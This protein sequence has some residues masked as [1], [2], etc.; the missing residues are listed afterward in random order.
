MTGSQF[1]YQSEAWAKDGAGRWTAAVFEQVKVLL[2]RW[3]SMLGDS[4]EM[5][6][7]EVVMVM[8]EARR[9]VGPAAEMRERMFFRQAVRYAQA[10]VGGPAVP[11]DVWAARRVVVKKKYIVLSKEEEARLLVNAAF[12]GQLVWRFVKVAL[13]TGLRMGTVLQARWGWVD[14]KERVMV[15]PASAMKTREAV[16][17]PMPDVP[18]E[19]QK[20][21]ELV[22][23]TK[24]TKEGKEQMRRWFAAAV[25]M[26]GLPKETRP[27]DLR[28]T[29]VARM[30]EKGCP[31]ATLMA[32]GGWRSVSTLV[33]H[34]TEKLSNSEVRKW[35]T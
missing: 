31:T 25:R 4:A 29:W 14:L 3:A 12:V 24:A 22:V 15:V 8:Q 20:D 34:Y 11:V 16:T 35:A 33:R 26:A 10:M 28:R 2:R 7:E 6:G 1:V 27:H 9:R 23:G 17:V 19:G 30:V 18:Y 21:S 5:G 32:L 13:G